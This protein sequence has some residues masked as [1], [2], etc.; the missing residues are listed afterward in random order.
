VTV[1]QHLL[2]PGK[3]SGF[4][5]ELGE[6]GVRDEQENPTLAQQDRC[7]LMAL[8]RATT[9]LQA[10]RQRGRIEAV[11]NQGKCEE[12]KGVA[13]QEGGGRR[14]DWQAEDGLRRAG[15]WQVSSKS[16]LKAQV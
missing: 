6:C 1:T 3:R 5:R 2:N 16:Q 15:V 11:G 8:L 10:R 7:A 14:S 4:R 9:K 13:A 12:G